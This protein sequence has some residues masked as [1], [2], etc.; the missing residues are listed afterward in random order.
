MKTRLIVPRMEDGGHR[1]RLW[2][3]C[4]AFWQ[5]ELP[6]DEGFEL[7]EGH[8]Q[9]DGPFNRSA[10]INRAAFGSWDIA[11]LLDSDTIVDPS[12]VCS[13]IEEARASGGLVLPFEERH[14]LSPQGTATILGGF[15]GSWRRWVTA[16]ERGRVSC[17]VIVPRKLWDRVGGFDERFEGWGGEDEAFHAACAALG[18][19]RR[20]TGAIWH[21]HHRAS[22]HHD[23][24]APLYRQA[25]ALCS[26]YHRAMPHPEQ[27]GQLLSEPRTP[28][29]IAVVALTTGT[30][31]TLVPTIASADENLSG[32]IGRRLIVVDG[33]PSR[34]QAVADAHPAWDVEQVVGGSYPRAVARA[35]D[36]A[37]GCGQ[38]WIF[39][40]EDDFTFE[41]TVD[42]A[43]MQGLIE[44]DDLVQLSLLRQPWFEPEID[45]GGVIAADPDAFTQRDG[46]VEHRAYWSMNPMLTRR[47]TLAEHLWPDA[48]DSE[49]R[50]GDLIFADAKARAGILGAIEDPP[51]V[52]HIGLE[53]AGTG[54]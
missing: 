22:T 20:K 4:R 30:R 36:R 46:Y 7:V 50:F 47:S 8:H 24:S 49:R 5:R 9:G 52:E 25:L 11:V 15:E 54:Y 6:A 26:R 10:A 37:L 3:F 14:M 53:R 28:D 41:D 1:D 51:R 40:L 33:P 39:W 17:C 12:Q 35:I 21:L 16:T 38:P 2:E 31:D 29:Q 48:R 13:A 23:R 44:R 18:S 45:A 27:M 32:A 42:L 43:E 19:V 34:A